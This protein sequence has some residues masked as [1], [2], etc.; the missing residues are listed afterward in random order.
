VAVMLK[1]KTL[2]FRKTFSSTCVAGRKKVDA[3]PSCVINKDISNISTRI[4][5]E[6]VTGFRINFISLREEKILRND[7]VL[8]T[9]IIL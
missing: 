7:N 5:V 8:K 6:S 1:N 2:S 3:E 4:C 9:G